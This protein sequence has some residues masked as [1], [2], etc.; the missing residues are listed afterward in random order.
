MLT[1]HGLSIKDVELI[2]VNFALSASILSGRVDAVIGAFRNF[3]LNQ[4]DIE[5]KPGI[6]FYPEEEG[7]PAYDELII[8]A[9]KGKLS[10]PR[11]SQFLESLEKG[12]Q[13]LVNH[14]NESWQHWEYGLENEKLAKRYCFWLLILKLNFEA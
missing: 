13:F 10:D 2:N 1:E 3:E 4:M 14:P 11:F 9:N 12:V 5:G 6:A 8:V 7:V